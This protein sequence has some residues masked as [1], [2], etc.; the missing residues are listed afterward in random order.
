MR[1]YGIGFAA[2]V[3]LC[4]GAATISVNLVDIA[5]SSG[6]TAP[7]TSGGRDK[8][9]YILETTGNGVAIFDY[10]GDGANDIFI[11]NGS[12]LEGRA[13]GAPPRTAHL[14]HND[15]RGNFTDVSRQAGFDIEGW[16]QGVCV[17]DYN[18]DGRP[19]LLETFY[20]YNRL[21]KN[22]GGGRFQDAT[23]EARL[24]VTGKRYGAG[25][26][27]DFSVRPG[28]VAAR[29]DSAI[30]SSHGLKITRSKG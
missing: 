21:Y 13:A 27:T 24:P 28:R 2:C 14:Y 15:G 17:G 16:G 26:P 10:D 8:K 25:S 22:T 5:A 1:L 9:T 20:G 29:H 3:L 23:R 4:G 6:L 11:A 12:T 30:H 7:N 19:D 18:N